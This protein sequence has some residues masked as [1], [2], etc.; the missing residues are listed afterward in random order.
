MA[1]PKPPKKLRKKF[2]R[3]LAAQVNGRTGEVLHG[4]HEGDPVTSRARA[5]LP[6][7]GSPT[8]EKVAYITD[9]MV[10]GE[11]N[12]YAT[13][14]M[15]CE[16]W[17]HSDETVRRHAAEAHRRLELDEELIKQTRSAHAVFCERIQREALAMTSHITGLPDFGAALKATELAA[18]FRGIDIDSAKRIEIS[19]KNG[20]A[21]TVTLGDVD[22][23]L[24]AAQQNTNDAVGVPGSD[25]AER[26]GQA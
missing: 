17:N 23:A 2:E 19:G 9:L 11:W 12:G 14:A 8:T 10:A 15:L 3:K 22:A 24:D 7:K 1:D 13:R 18:K 25:G 20:G 5:A 4:G 21:I 26:K 16:A 6:S